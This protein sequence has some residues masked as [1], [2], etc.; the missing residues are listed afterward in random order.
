MQVFRLDIR[1]AFLNGKV[2]EE[3]YVKQPQGYEVKGNKEKVYLFHI[4]FYGLKHAPHAWNNKI[5][6]YF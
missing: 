2:E 5:N 1:L 4:A 3:V 6:A